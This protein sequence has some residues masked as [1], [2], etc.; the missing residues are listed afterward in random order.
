MENIYEET[1]RLPYG[2][3]A[4]IKI[5]VQKHDD[6]INLVIT[7]EYSNNKLIDTV[8]LLLTQAV[9]NKIVDKLGKFK[10]S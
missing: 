2:G 5:Q 9:Y 1:Q 8:D 4:A 6:L 7:T 10:R 3:H